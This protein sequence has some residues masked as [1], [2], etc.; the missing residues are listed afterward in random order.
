[1]KRTL[2]FFKK[3][4]PHLC[5]ILSLMLLTFFVLDQI[6]P[7]M[8]FLDN[9]AARWILFADAVLTTIL[10]VLIVV[11]RELQEPKQIQKKEGDKK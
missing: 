2:S 5:L 10:S 3:I 4:L 6:N 8:A 11:K 9:T 7:S 1:M